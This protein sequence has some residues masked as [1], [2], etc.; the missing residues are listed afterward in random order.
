MMVSLGWL[1]LEMTNSPLAL[2]MVWAARSAPHFLFGILAGAVADRI[3]RRK[4]LIWA[5]TLLAATSLAM[6]F[7]ISQGWIQLWHTL[8]L[9]FILG[10]LITFDMTSRQ[11]LVVDIVGP[12][13]AMSALSMNAVALRVMGVFGGGAAGVII[14][15]FGTE[16]CFYI[17]AVGFLLGTIALIGIRGVV[18]ET[19]TGTPSIRK[20]FVEGLK[21][22]GQNQ[23][24]LL[25]AVMAVFCEIFGFSHQAILVIFARDILDAGAI[26]LGMLTT[27]ESV[28]ALLALLGLASLGN[29]QHKG[30]LILGIFLGYGIFL[31]FFSQS[32]W[33]PMS[34]FLIMVVG[35]MAASFDAMQHTMLQLNVAD[36]Q[37]GRAMGIWQLSIGFMPIGSLA[38]GAMATLLGAQLAISINGT[39]IV[40][41]FLILAVFASRLRRA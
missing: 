36:E 35:A 24:I 23:I 8:I 6:G 15:F 12:E 40:V 2:G 30:R 26:G 18:R 22:I 7:L 4:L 13:D 39:V 19:S 37:R 25:L 33:Y 14:K 11:T 1:T 16:W 31:I 41:I 20:N 28:G 27:M 10:L 29:Y 17:M 5:F 21:I 32:P 9:T 3:D 38:V 34:L